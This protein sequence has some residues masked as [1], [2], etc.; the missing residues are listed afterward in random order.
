MA[1][2]TIDDKE[3]ESDDL[4]EDAQA[5]LVSLQFVNGEIQRLQAKLAA[6]QTA[7]AA[8]SVALGGALKDED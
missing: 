5:Q 1:T 7:A 6:M 4:S 8:Y 3:Y 2:V